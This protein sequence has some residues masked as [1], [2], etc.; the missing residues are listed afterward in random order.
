MTVATLRADGW[1]QATQV[2]YVADGLNLFFLISR[3]G[4]KYANLMA[5]DRASIAIGAD[6]AT[7]GDIEGLSMAAHVS[8]VKD[9][10]HL[11]HFTAALADAHQGYFDPDT[12]RRQT[13]ALMQARPMLISVIDFRQ[14]QGH[15]DLVSVGEGGM[16]SMQPARPADWGPAPKPLA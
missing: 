1:P 5:D 3:R 10:P 15:A 6:F 7:P 8:E 16:C 9:E 4:Q 13:S 2:C 11:G 14:G 12:I